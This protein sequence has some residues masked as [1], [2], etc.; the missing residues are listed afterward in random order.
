M[1]KILVITP[2]KF[3][4]TDEELE[5]FRNRHYELVHEAE[6][7]L[8]EYCEIANWDKDYDFL[9]KDTLEN[10]KE[11]FATCIDMLLDRETDYALFADGWKNS[12]ECNILHS[13]ADN[14]KVHIIY[15]A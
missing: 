4:L 3:G 15:M 9:E 12:Y 2:P 5:A 14:F 8:D 7:R 6:I 1:K 13:I 10:K 11:Y